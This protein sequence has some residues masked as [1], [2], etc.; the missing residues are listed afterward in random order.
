MAPLAPL[1]LSRTAACALVALCAALAL[2]P[3][4]ARTTA[5]ALPPVALADLPREA[6]D[7]NAAIRNGGPFAYPRDGVVFGNRERILPVEP[8]G[9]YHEYTVPTPG[10]KSRGAR[11][12]RRDPVEPEGDTPVRRRAV[13]QGVEQESELLPLILG[14]DPERLEDLGLHVGLVDAD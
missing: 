1:R 7:V 12:Q 10:V 8:R 6:R 3:A 9:Y 2:A 13:G 11:H 14:T 5:D 4:A